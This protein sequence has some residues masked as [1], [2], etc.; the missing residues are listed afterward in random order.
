MNRGGVKTPPNFIVWPQKSHNETCNFLFSARSLFVWFYYWSIDTIGPYV[1]SGK[2][3]CR[4]IFEHTRVKPKYRRLTFCSRTMFNQCSLEI[5]L[6]CIEGILSQEVYTFKLQQFRRRRLSWI[7]FKILGAYRVVSWGARR[8]PE[9]KRAPNV[10]ARKPNFVL[11]ARDTNSHSRV[12][13]SRGAEKIS[14]SEHMWEDLSDYPG[15]RESKRLIFAIL[16]IRVLGGQRGVAAKGR[17]SNSPLLIRRV[18]K[19]IF[20]LLWDSFAPSLARQRRRRKNYGEGEQASR[21]AS[22]RRFY[23]ISSPSPSHY[24]A[25]NNSRQKNSQMQ[26][27]EQQVFQ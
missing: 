1:M 15:P 22:C 12:F 14:H 6:A 19:F 9:Q 7:D 8:H 26:S 24:A 2:L 18:A 23:F 25:R 13:C 11:A 5:S 4:Q 21:F 10:C 27:R 20:V 3:H 16:R 17:I